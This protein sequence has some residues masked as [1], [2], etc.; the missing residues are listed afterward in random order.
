M[1]V[2]RIESKGSRPGLVIASVENE[3]QKK[4]LMKSKIKLKYSRDYQK[5]YIENEL[6]S[7]AR[8]QL[9]NM[10]TVLNGIGREKDFVVVNG[11]IQKRANNM[12]GGEYDNVNGQRRPEREEWTPVQGRHFRGRGGRGWSARQN[13]N[14]NFRCHVVNALNF[15]ILCLCET[16]LRESDKIHVEGYTCFQRNRDKVHVNSKRGSGGVAALVKNDLLKYYNVEILNSEVQD[17]LWIKLSNENDIICLC[18]CYLPPENSVYN[19]SLVFYTKLLEQ[20]YMYQNI[21][22]LY[23]CGDFNS[24]C[25]DAQDFIEGVDNVQI[26]E[27]VDSVS[28]RNGDLL[29]EFLVDCNMCMVNGRIGSQDFT[30]IKGTGKSVV[31]Y[32]LTPH[33]QLNEVI[34]FKVN[35]MSDL[36]TELSLVGYE[37][38][39]DH[40]LLEW[41]IRVR[42]DMS[43]VE[44][45]ENGKGANRVKG[46]RKFKLDGLNNEPFSSE[47]MQNVLRDT[48]CR[49]EVALNRSK[50]V[51]KAFIELKHLLIKELELTCKEL[52]PP[53][54][55]MR[56]NKCKRKPYWSEEL[57]DSWNKTCDA[58]RQ[59][60]RCK[61]IGKS[62]L[63]T[64]F[65]Q[66]RKDFDKLNRLANDRK[67]RQT[68]QIRSETG[69]IISD[70]DSV[71][72]KWKIDY[73]KLYNSADMNGSYDDEFLKDIKNKLQN[74]NNL[75]NDNNIDTT[76]LNRAIERDE[77][78]EA[79][80]R[81]KQ[82]HNLLGDLSDHCQIS[83]LLNIQCKIKGD[84]CQTQ[85]SLKSYKWN[86]NSTELFQEALSSGSMQQKILNFNK[87]EYHSDI[88]NMIKDVNT[89]FYEAANLSLKQKPTKKST[90]KLKQNVKKKPNWLDASLSK[91]K[92]NLNDKEKLLQKYPFDPVIRSSFFSLLK[93]YRKTRKKKIRDFRQDLIDKL[94]NLKDENPS[95]YWALLHELSDTNRE[96]TTS[97]VSTDAWFSYFKNLN[98]KDTNAS[99]DYLKDKI[100]DMEREKIFTELDN[101]ISKAEIE[102]AIN[103]MDEFMSKMNGLENPSQSTPRLPSHRLSY[104]FM[105]ESGYASGRPSTESELI[106]CDIRKLKEQ[107]EQLESFK[108]PTEDRLYPNLLDDNKD[109]VPSGVTVRSK[110]RSTDTKR[111]NEPIMKTDDKNLRQNNSTSDKGLYLAVALRG[112]AQGILG[113]LPI[114]KQQNYK[115]LVNALEQRFAPPNQTELYRVQL[116]ERRQKASESLPELGQS[117]RRLIN[118]AYPTVPEDVRDTLA[119]QY[120][121]EALAD[122]EMRIRIKQS[123]PQG[124]NDA[125]R[126]A[127]ELETYNRAEKQLKDGRSYLRQAS[128]T[129]EK[130]SHIDKNENSDHIALTELMSKMEQKLQELQKDMRELKNDSNSRQTEEPRTQNNNGRGRFN[131]GGFR[132]RG[133]RYNNGGRGFSGNTNGNRDNSYNGQSNYNSFNDSRGRG[134]T[135]MIK[136]SQNQKNGLHGN[137]GVSTAAHEAGMYVDTDLYGLS[138]SLLVDTGATVTIISEKT[139][140][141]IPRARQPDLMSS[142]QQVFTA[143]GDQLN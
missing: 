127:V 96:N 24:R 19:D 99:C 106:D 115:A 111:N 10:M 114:D 55:N 60:K 110:Y 16:F 12:R 44:Q 76:E 91:L 141:R 43:E 98:E 47:N 71:L 137:I 46:P 133:G 116:T 48:I 102:K 135:R 89:I 140:N 42:T 82:V 59:W 56:T 8:V 50:D 142:N 49:I 41:G 143:S 136:S 5:V 95:Q 65:I 37:S 28:N 122:S 123:R 68:F 92:N 101:L 9:S 39:P 64:R 134:T 57:Q 119:K 21:G 3:E 93:H 125:L 45:N 17:I 52:K 120:F 113:D 103:E 23:I 30:H 7:E 6:T 126:V 75:V 18:V 104:D 51:N 128:Q 84:T 100:K 85:M 2:L 117:I 129:E 70:I 62:K 105:E 58:E 67:S 77:V 74:R 118:Q 26:R 94:D 73:E 22:K 80:F 107:L 15:D 139:Y 14:S 11:K 81:A 35:T 61:S 72:E 109:Y 13:D 132:Q 1:H 69:E 33:E 32:V 66:S 38:I 124:L 20:V 87:T 40:S 4:K 130:E 63:R 36:V 86:E 25:G 138:A 112:Q 79:V 97:D 108:E 53:V 131:R 54:S 121:I 34:N 29:I 78:R 27:I 31:D 83:V 90:S 88:N